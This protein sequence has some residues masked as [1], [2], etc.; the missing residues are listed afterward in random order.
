M[1]QDSHAVGKEQCKVEDPRLRAALS[2]SEM[3]VEDLK[4]KLAALIRHHHVEME[5]LPAIHRKVD[6]ESSR[7]LTRIN[8]LPVTSYSR[9]KAQEEG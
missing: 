7:I 6:N 1:Q 9:S 8:Q 2:K 3:Q 5:A 4:Y